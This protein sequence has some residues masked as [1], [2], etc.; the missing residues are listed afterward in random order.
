MNKRMTK[1]ILEGFIFHR[2]KIASSYF[3]WLLGRSN[4]AELKRFEIFMREISL[5]TIKNNG[6]VLM[7][8][9]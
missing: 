1:L 3:S 2:R 6:F 8:C 4:M 7:K 5:K 9:N